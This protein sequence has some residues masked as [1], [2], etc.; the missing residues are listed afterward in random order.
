MSIVNRLQAIARKARTRVPVP[1]VVRAMLKRV[2]DRGT[3]P[4]P[5]PIATEP[6]PVAPKKPSWE[7]RSPAELVDHI[8]GHYHEGLRRDLP[9]LIAAARPN[10][11]DH[12]AHPALPGQLAD[13]LA[14][15]AMELESH[16]LKEETMLFPM[17]RPGARGGALD[18]GRPFQRRHR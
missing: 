2:Q 1:D 14:A 4:P 6:E 17:L 16:M 10:D 13:E 15:L 3:P 9:V 5:A 11:R 8:V 18:L 7:L 12:A